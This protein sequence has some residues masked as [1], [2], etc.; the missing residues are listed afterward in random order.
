MKK[1]R[2]GFWVTLGI[3]LAL[4]AG[5]IYLCYKLAYVEVSANDIHV[6]VRVISGEVLSQSPTEVKLIA[7][8]EYQV[9]WSAPRGA[10]CWTYTNDNRK[11]LNQK[12][13]QDFSPKADISETYSISCLS[14]KEGGVSK[15]VR[16]DVYSPPTLGT[17]LKG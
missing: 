6:D 3:L 16:V 7:P 4:V 17:D 9:T 8:A 12:A 2:V 5:T 11:E 10:V 13:E 1:G 15:H 14:D